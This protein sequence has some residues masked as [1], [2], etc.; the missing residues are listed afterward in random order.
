MLENHH[1]LFVRLLSKLLIFPSLI[2]LFYTFQIQLFA[3]LSSPFNV[4]FHVFFILQSLVNFV[5]LLSMFLTLIVFPSELL[6]FP[7]LL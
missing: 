1:I 2:L 4:I 3:L 7:F 6:F 5:L